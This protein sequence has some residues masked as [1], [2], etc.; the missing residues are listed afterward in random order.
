MPANASAARAI[1]TSLPSRVPMTPFVTALSEPAIAAGRPDWNVAK[2]QG[3]AVSLLTHELFDEIAFPALL[4]A[5][6][7]NLSD[8]IVAHTDYRERA[9]PPILHRKETLL[10]PDPSTPGL[11]CADAVGGGAQ[12][13]RRTAPHRHP[14]SLARARGG[15]LVWSCGALGC[16]AERQCPKV[17]AAS[18]RYRPPGPVPTRSDAG[19]APDRQREHDSA[20]LRVRPG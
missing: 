1:C 16:C 19:L 8:G 11:C 7:V 18:H 2:V 15:C 13:L 5:V 3:D 10:R 6:R 17:A 9:N 20:R 4:T 12:A 14:Q